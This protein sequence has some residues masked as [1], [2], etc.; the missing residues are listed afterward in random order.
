MTPANAPRRPPAPFVQD[1]LR[2]PVIV[3]VIEEARASGDH[4]LRVGRIATSC[5]ASSIG[6]CSCAP[7][8][9]LPQERQ[10]PDLT[11]GRGAVRARPVRFG[12]KVNAVDA[13]SADRRVDPESLRRRSRQDCSR[14]SMHQ[15][16]G[17]SGPQASDAGNR[18]GVEV[19]D[20]PH[21]AG[22]NS[23]GLQVASAL[24]EMPSCAW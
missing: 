8:R 23:L 14:S 13:V 16:P 22:D 12:M 1:G 7:R 20:R 21:V 10:G 18:E 24:P 17:R 5:Q 11:R 19:M 2:R 9:R 6:V 15:L 3:A 4:Q